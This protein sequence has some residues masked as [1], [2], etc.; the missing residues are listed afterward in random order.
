MEQQRWYHPRLHRW[1][2]QD[3]IKDGSNWY[4]YVANNPTNSIDPSGL[5]DEPGFF[6]RAWSNVMKPQLKGLV[7]SPIE[8]GKG[9]L[10]MTPP[11]QIYS[12]ANGDHPIQQ[13]INNISEQ[14]VLKGGWKTFVDNSPA[15]PIVKHSSLGE[16]TYG[17]Y[18]RIKGL[19][20]DSA[21]DASAVRNGS[22]N[23]ALCRAAF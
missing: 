11:G 15:V 19:F 2:S 6:Q 17:N 5:G 13:G 23:P 22:T 21:E 10:K 12:L 7:N 8:I 3:P 16:A 18:V 1:M 14:G 20:P 4:A 9:I